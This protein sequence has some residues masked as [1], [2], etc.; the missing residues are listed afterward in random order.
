MTCLVRLEGFEP[1]TY[2]SVESLGSMPK[3]LENPVKNALYAIY[4]SFASAC[5]H[6]SRF[7]GIFG[8]SAQCAEDSALDSWLKND[9]RIGYPAG[10]GRVRI[11]NG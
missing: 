11:P 6:P 10:S 9:F 4:G 3:S 7:A 5:E 8:I 2:G 1:P